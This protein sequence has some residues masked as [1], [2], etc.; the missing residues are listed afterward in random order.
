MDWGLLSYVFDTYRSCRP[1]PKGMNLTLDYWFP[2]RDSEGWKQDPDGRGSDISEDNLEVEA[3]EASGQITG[4]TSKGDSAEKG[5]PKTVRAEQHWFS[6][7]QVLKKLT[8]DNDNPLQ[9]V[10]PTQIAL[11]WYG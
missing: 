11:E 9:P 1:F 3:Q 8:R 4:M 2:H 7:L 6:D 5:E 10:R